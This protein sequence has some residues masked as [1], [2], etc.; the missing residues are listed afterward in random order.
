V[1]PFNEQQEQQPPQQ[2]EQG[3]GQGQ[4]QGQHQDQQFN[5]LQAWYPVAIVSQLPADRP[6]AN[7]LLGLP[8]VLWRDGQEQ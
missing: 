6:S 5:W 7:Q 4:G 2:Q 1:A 8:L 3:Q